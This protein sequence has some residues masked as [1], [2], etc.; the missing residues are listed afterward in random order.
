MALALGG[1]AHFGQLVDLLDVNATVLGEEHDV[2]VRGA[3]EQVFDEIFFA[4]F[5]A[6]DALA[7]AAL[8]AVGADGGALDVALVARW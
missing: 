2:V 7:A 6:H 1:A 5:H 4:L 8:G 3:G